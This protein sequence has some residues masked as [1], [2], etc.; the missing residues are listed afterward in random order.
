VTKENMDSDA[1]RP[2]LNPP[3]AEYLD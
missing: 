2:L 1:V 3:L